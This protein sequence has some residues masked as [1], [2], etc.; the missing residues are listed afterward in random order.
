MLPRTVYTALLLPTF[1][2]NIAWLLPEQ[3]EYADIFKTNGWT[4]IYSSEKVDI[5]VFGGDGK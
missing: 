5:N 3:E 2:R 4:V 1:D